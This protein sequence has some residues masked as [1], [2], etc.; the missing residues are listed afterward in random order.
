MLSMIQVQCPHCGARGQ[1]VVPPVGTVIIGPCPQCQELVVV[2]SGRVLPLSKDIM[3]NGSFEERRDHLIDVLRGFLQER[4]TEL[5]KEADKI[6][7]E[8]D[9]DTDDEDLAFLEDVDDDDED[10]FEEHPRREAPEP[11]KGKPIADS[12]V[13]KFISQDLRLIDN[14]DYF[15]SIFG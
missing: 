15:R 11:G 12:E 9:D 14:K 2:F 6:R 3:V 1:M 4:I 8:K 10:D 5:L 7:L 13:E